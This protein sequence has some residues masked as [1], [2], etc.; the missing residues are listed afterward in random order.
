MTQCKQDSIKERVRSKAVITRTVIQRCY[1]MNDELVLELE[2]IDLGIVGS[3]SFIGLSSVGISN[4]L[5]A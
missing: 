3:P 5:I 1:L 4:P 2:N